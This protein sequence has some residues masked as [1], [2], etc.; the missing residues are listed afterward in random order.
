MPELGMQGEGV[1]VVKE[2]WKW[3]TS[4]AYIFLALVSA[5]RNASSIPIA[6]STPAPNISVRQTVFETVCGRLHP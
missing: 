6:Q 5:L 3:A 1:W 4:F 2:L